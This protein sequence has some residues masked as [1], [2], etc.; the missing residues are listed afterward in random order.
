MYV[1]VLTFQL[2]ANDRQQ[3]ARF[4]ERAVLGLAEFDGYV[5]D[6]CLTR[7]EHDLCGGMIAWS[8]WK[9]MESFRHSELYAKLRMSPLVESVNDRTFC[10]ES[11]ATPGILESDLIAAA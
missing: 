4:C 11:G 10:V 6:S 9:S 7:P 8:D 3:A 2:S 5:T 1:Q